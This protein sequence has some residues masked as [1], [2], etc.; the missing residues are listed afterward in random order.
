MATPSMTPQNGNGGKWFDALVKL[1]PILAGIALVMASY[2]GLQAQVAN[3][4]EKIQVL[5][6][7]SVN[8]DQLQYVRDS[9][10]R[11]ERNQELLDQKVD[12]IQ[13]RQ[14]DR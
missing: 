1:W 10:G 2:Y 9:L 12:Q 14:R 11:I 13:R 4:A 5:Q 6:K 7:T 3:Q 8:Q